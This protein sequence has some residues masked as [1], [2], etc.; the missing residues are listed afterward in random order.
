MIHEYTRFC[1]GAVGSKSQAAQI[2]NC[3]LL[4]QSP[5]PAQR[6]VLCAFTMVAQPF[7]VLS[8]PRKNGTTVSPPPPKT[9]ALFLRQLWTESFITP[10]WWKS[11]AK[12]PCES[13]T[14]YILRTRMVIP[15]ETVQVL[16]QTGDAPLPP[17]SPRC[18]PRGDC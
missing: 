5:S 18:H 2:R 13:G 1:Q 11:K 10:T 12:C 17:H 14:G 9:A 6:T 7:S 8:I 16:S 3:L 15:N 4:D